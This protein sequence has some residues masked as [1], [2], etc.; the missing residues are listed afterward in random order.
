MYWKG[1]AA[2]VV[3]FA[4]KPGSATGMKEGTKE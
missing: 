3:D 1:V 2:A 4:R